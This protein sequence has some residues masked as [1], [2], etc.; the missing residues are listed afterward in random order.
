MIRGAHAPSRAEFGALA[1]LLC[2]RAGIGAF[3]SIVTL[4][5]LVGEGAD[6][7]TRGACAPRI[8]CVRALLQLRA[9]NFFECGLIS[10]KST[11]IDLVAA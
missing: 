3:L 5:L 6:E 1:E 8:I 2:G 10:R 11:K 4:G 9:Q 7:C